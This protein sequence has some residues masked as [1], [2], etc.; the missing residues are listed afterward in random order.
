LPILPDMEN[1]R[2]RRTQRQ[3]QQQLKSV[4]GVTDTETLDSTMQV[5]RDAADKSTGKVTE[6]L[7]QEAETAAAEEADAKVTSAEMPSARTPIAAAAAAEA[8]EASETSGEHD[9]A[10]GEGHHSYH[11]PERSFPEAKAT[12]AAVLEVNRAL[13]KTLAERRQLLR[14][15]EATVSRLEERMVG[16]AMEEPLR[17]RQLVELRS[18]NAPSAKT[19][20]EATLLARQEAKLEA[21]I[22]EL[23]TKNTQL[24]EKHRLDRERA[25]ECHSRLKTLGKRERK[26]SLHLEVMASEL[27][28]VSNG[29]AEV[30][31]S[32]RPVDYWN[33]SGLCVQKLLTRGHPSE[34]RHHSLDK[35]EKKISG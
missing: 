26:L 12:L 28:A 7:T 25:A 23:N 27:T 33:L 30:D 29:L 17:H 8:G 22:E 4:E 5:S 16:S 3:Q 10:E 15:S 21:K 13:H 19:T 35:T 9:D 11:G 31:A 20:R 14:S 24:A 2:R 18:P 34:K 1:H 6:Q 32:R